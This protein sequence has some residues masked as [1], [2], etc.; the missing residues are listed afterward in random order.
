[1]RIVYIIAA[2]ILATALSHAAPPPALGQPG[3]PVEITNPLAAEKPV[4][5]SYW[6]PDPGLFLWPMSQLHDPVASTVAI[7]PAPGTYRVLVAANIGGLVKQAVV[8]VNISAPAKVAYGPDAPAPA[9]LPQTSQGQRAEVGQLPLT[10]TAQP[11]V[12]SAAFPSSPWYYLPTSSLV[13]P[14]PVPQCW[15]GRCR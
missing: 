15:G 11:A 2:L 4:S 7:A 3:Q 5:V 9:Q 10:D 8:V 6:S 1:M 13:S 14:S 12:Y